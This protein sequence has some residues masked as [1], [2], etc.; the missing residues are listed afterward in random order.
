LNAR[1][2]LKDYMHLLYLRTLYITGLLLTSLTRCMEGPQVEPS[3]FKSNASEEFQFKVLPSDSLKQINLPKSIVFASTTLRDMAQDKEFNAN[4]PIRFTTVP[5]EFFYTLRNFFQSGGTINQLA[6]KA[7]FPQ[8]PDKERLFKA[9]LEYLDFENLEKNEPGSPIRREK[10][11]RT[12][13]KSLPVKTVQMIVGQDEKIVEI[14]ERMVLLSKTLFDYY[15]DPYN[16]EK[17][18]NFQPSFDIDTTLFTILI[19]FFYQEKPI[20]SLQE[21]KFEDPAANQAFKK[22][23]EYLDFSNKDPLLNKNPEFIEMA[24]EL[25][26]LSNYFKN[27]LVFQGG[28]KKSTRIMA[29]NIPTIA[30]LNQ[31]L[32]ALRNAG[33]TRKLDQINVLIK[34]TETL[35]LQSLVS[36]IRAADLLDIPLIYKALL[37]RIALSLESQESLLHFQRDPTY[38]LFEGI[39][40]TIIADIL[41]Q[42]S[43]LLIP[44]I[45][46]LR[47]P[48]LIRKKITLEYFENDFFIDQIGS[49][50]AY[51]TSKANNLEFS[52]IS[53]LDLTTMDNKTTDFE[54]EL[55]NATKII[56]L[57][58]PLNTDAALCDFN[59][60]GN[61]FAFSGRIENSQI[62]TLWDL[63]KNKKIWG[64]DFPYAQNNQPPINELD[65]FCF[66]HKSNNLLGIDKTK[67]C[68]FIDSSNKTF[69]PIM[70]NSGYQL[71]R[72]DVA[73]GPKDICAFLYCFDQYS[74]SLD[75]CF[76]NLFRLENL[77]LRG[78]QL[79]PLKEIPLASIRF[80]IDQLGH[81]QV[82]KRIRFFDDTHIIIALETPTKLSMIK[83]L[84]FFLLNI[85]RNQA[86][87]LGTM[88]ITSELRDF[89]YF[90]QQL[91]YITEFDSTDNN[92]LELFKIQ[93]E[94]PKA[95]SIFSNIS[96]LMLFLIANKRNK[97]KTPWFI[98][99]S[100]SIYLNE[101]VTDLYRQLPEKIKRLIIENVK[102]FKDNPYQKKRK[103][104]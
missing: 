84:S 60:E 25:K 36:L 82:V 45:G 30:S 97:S 63:E 53:I 19:D 56:P 61:F 58:R 37:K 68:F 93:L 26:K 13:K 80:E 43:T 35:D 62:F 103:R 100:P 89:A 5:A 90:N 75:R 7:F 54:T 17:V 12:R 59:T 31:L 18:I 29:R 79:T 87:L 22:I 6:V 11:Q 98:D 14:P 3:E 24:P 44:H 102:L 85:Y 23:I 99:P 65:F 71:E 32:I 8:D 52:S 74:A 46:G 48:E 33:K 78:K 21:I 42:F 2:N 10:R 55:K 73:S 49:K 95:S 70:S 67:N 94:L 104:K 83:N 101:Q 77:P 20:E 28:S 1:L 91:T 57:D 92:Y 41:D 16:P 88:R 50:L 86:V 34:E 39:P 96:Q 69:S 27:M 72:A 64:V 4:E 40:Q 66:L 9:F 38:F 15:Y 51:L 47:L 81:A 76:I